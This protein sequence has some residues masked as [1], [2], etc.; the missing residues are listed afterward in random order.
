MVNVVGWKELGLPAPE[1]LHA[2]TIID[3]RMAR[4][5]NLT[6]DLIDARIHVKGA[7]KYGRLSRYEAR[8]SVLCASGPVYATAFGWNVLDVLHRAFESAE[9]QI[10]HRVAY[11]TAYGVLS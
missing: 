2:R 3:R 4:L 5:R 9:N 1:D 8:V 11:E 7:A 10:R 6:D